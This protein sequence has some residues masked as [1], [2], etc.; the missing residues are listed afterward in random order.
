MMNICLV[1]SHFSHVQTAGWNV[2]LPCT[3][4]LTN[5]FYYT[6]RH[7]S[8]LLT[9][10]SISWKPLD[11]NAAKATYMQCHRPHLYIADEYSSVAPC[12]RPI[13]HT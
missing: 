7:S 1:L 2:T 12:M 11:L 5:V 6:A 9:S 8:L 13:T 3:Y 10:T 4:Q